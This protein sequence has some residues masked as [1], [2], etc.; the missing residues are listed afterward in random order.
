MPLQIGLALGF[1]LDLLADVVEVVLQVAE[2]AEEGGAFASL[3]V[4][5]PL[6]VLELCR[7]RDLDLGELVYLGLGFLEL[8]QEVAVL[9]RQLLLGGVEVVD[10]AGQLLDLALAL[11]VLVLELLGDLLLGRLFCNYKIQLVSWDSL[12][13][14]SPK[15]ALEFLKIFSMASNVERLKSKLEVQRHRRQKKAKN[16]ASK[17]EAMVGNLGW[18]KWQRRTQDAGKVFRI[19]CRRETVSGW[20]LAIIFW[21]L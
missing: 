18:G 15:V 7:E 5:E 3:L 21:T 1:L 19:C 8:A 11:V 4:G 16:Q 17:H 6:G 10:G 14:G 12:G 13:V 20:L 9:D 2:L